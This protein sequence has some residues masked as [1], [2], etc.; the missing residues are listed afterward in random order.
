MLVLF[1]SVGGYEAI[2]YDYKLSTYFDDDILTDNMIQELNYQNE[3]NNEKLIS[4][5]FRI[6]MELHAGYI[7]RSNPQPEYDEIEEDEPPRL[8][9][10]FKTDHCVICM[11][12]PSN[13][14]FYDCMHI[15][16]CSECEEN[17]PLHACPYCKTRTVE[18]IVFKKYVSKF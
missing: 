15:C 18:K 1:F 4:D 5:P 14:L 7:N 17:R 3:G 10:S 9:R 16:T 8:T 6:V 12:N 2:L 13:I 11:D